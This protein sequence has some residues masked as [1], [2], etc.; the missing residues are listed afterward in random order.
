[1]GKASGAGSRRVP[2]VLPGIPPGGAL[3]RDASTGTQDARA[4]RNPALFLDLLKRFFFPARL[5]AL[6]GAPLLCA[7]MPARPAISIESLLLEMTNRDERARFPEPAFT[8]KQFSSY[9]RESVAPDKPGWFANRDRSMFLRVENNNGRREFVMMDTEGPGAIVRFWM[10]FSGKDSGRGTLRIYIDG[11]PA[12]AIEGAAFDILSGG[13]VAGAPLAASVPEAT[14]YQR[15]GHNLYFPIPYAKHCK[16]TYESQGLREDDYGA[17]KPGTEAVYYNIN[18]RTYAP[19]VEV[20]S[21]SRTEMQKNKDLVAAT[22]KKLAD[23]ERELSAKSSVLRLD[24][25]LQ[26]GESRTFEAN[27]AGAIQHLAMRLQAENQEQALRSTVL[28]IAFDDE[29][30]VWVPV[31]DFFGIGYKQ[32]YTNTWYTTAGEDGLMQSYWIMPFAKNCA[33]TLSNLGGQPVRIV[34]ASASIKDWNW[35]DR[36]MHFGAYWH[37]YTRIQASP[38]EQASDINFVSLKGKGVYAGDGIVLFNTNYRWWGEGDEKIYVDGETF[39]SHFGTGTEDYYGYA[40]CRPET[41]TGH[42]F[43]A[44]PLGTGNFTPRYT[45]NA[46]VRALDGI[47]FERSLHFDMELWSGGHMRIN[48]APVVFWYMVPGGKNL[49]ERDLAGVREPVAL[50]R[51]DIYSPALDEKLSVEAENLIWVST[52]SGV[53]SYQAHA[54]LPWSGGLQLCWKD[55][56][57]GNRASFSFNSH[58]AGRFAFTGLFT[59]AR[60]Y[61]V[62]DLYLN[63]EKIFS[64]LDLG[65]ELDIKPVKVGAVN[66]LKGANVLEVELVRHAKDAAK[67]SHFGI[68]KLVFE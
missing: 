52:P 65:G 24:A 23:G 3:C 59:T 38:H 17:K 33:I 30:T 12:P 40:W 2:R 47:P 46:R 57:V 58:V 20:V 45:V 9:D 68:D 18:H 11:E 67:K 53:V 56:E 7:A 36:S 48:Y 32:L 27:H 43:V 28:E 66:L 60:D 39:P 62:F 26:P 6:L 4:P 1:L 14:L 31:G 21:Y 44:Q 10:T 16:I 41:F 15:R 61:G 64:K 8:C 63:G 42:P 55:A 25:D 50:D 29:K 35:D 19:S 22:L 34:D 37:Q 5:V 49:A 13:L 51:A 54:T